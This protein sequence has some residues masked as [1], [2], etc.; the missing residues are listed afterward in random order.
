[1]TL[2]RMPVEELLEAEKAVEPK[3]DKYIDAETDAVANICQVI[4]VLVT[5]CNHSHGQFTWAVHMGSSAFR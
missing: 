2:L 4:C 5:Y 3:Q 1:M